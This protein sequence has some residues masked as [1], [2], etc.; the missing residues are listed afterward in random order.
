MLAVH[1]VSAFQQTANLEKVH[2]SNLAVYRNLITD[3]WVSADKIPLVEAAIEAEERA[4]RAA[5]AL[6]KQAEGLRAGLE[7]ALGLKTADVALRTI[8]S[9]SWVTRPF[10]AWLAR[11][12][13]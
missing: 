5:P 7:R 4:Y 3:G 8:H 9:V 10:R 2:E 11:R 12:R 1:R 6:K 13:G